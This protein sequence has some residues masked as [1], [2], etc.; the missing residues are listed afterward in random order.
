MRITVLRNDASVPMGHVERVARD[1]S[2][3]IDLVALDA[4][5]PLP[6][7]DAVSAIV[8][9]GG[10]MGA[11]DDDEYHRFKDERTVSVCFSD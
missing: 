11:Y 1:R 3:A 6:S 7:V 5:D 4:G 2:I 8:V 9:L 10:S